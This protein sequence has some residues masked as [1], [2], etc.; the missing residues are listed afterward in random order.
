MRYADRDVTFYPFPG[1]CFFLAWVFEIFGTTIL[2]PR[3]IVVLQFCLFVCLLFVRAA[4]GRLVVRS[5]PTV[6][7]S[8]LHVAQPSQGLDDFGARLGPNDI[9][10]GCAR[11]VAL[12]RPRQPLLNIRWGA[13]RD[14]L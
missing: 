9:L 1:A 8:S 13:L 4:A 11:D 2:V 7:P 3:W 14:L 12:Q 6:S 10:I 5:G